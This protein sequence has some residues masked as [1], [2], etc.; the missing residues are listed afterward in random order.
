MAWTLIHAR[1][2]ILKDNIVAGIAEKVDLE[3]EWN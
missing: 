1:T 2:K 3:C